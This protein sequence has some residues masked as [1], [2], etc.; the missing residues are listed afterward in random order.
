M[1][2]A[3]LAAAASAQELRPLAVRAGG[4]VD[5]R[6]G[7][8]RDA[9]VVEI[10]DGRVAAVRRGGEA[11]AAGP[12][13]CDLGSD[14]MLLP[15]LID[16]HAHL[17]MSPEPD[18]DYGE[19]SAASLALLGVVHARRTLLAGFT[20]VR[21]PFG[22][23]Y[24]DVALRDAI[25]AG[26]V[27]GPRM[28]VSG[29]GL[30]MTGGHGAVGNWAPPGLELR[31]GAASV[32]DGADAIRRE[33]RLH[34]KYGVD[35][36]KV[37]ATGGI[38]TEGTEPGAASYTREEIQAA[39]E[40]AVKRGQKVAAHAHGTQGIRNAVEAGVHSIEHGSFLDLATARLMVER[41]TFLVPDALADE[42]SLTDG[43]DATAAS[44]A[45]DKARAVSARFRESVR[46]AH[47]TGVRIAF[48]TD[49]GVYPHGLNGRQFALYVELGM[50]PMEAIVSATGDA[51]E[52]IGV[53]DRLGTI[54]P[55]ML[56]DLI[57]VRG[58]PLA[59]VG[60]LESIPFVMKGGRVVKND[61]GC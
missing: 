4:L 11:R 25:A 12:G 26:W 49:A 48:G 41:G 50:S 37:I 51:A 29:P 7:V 6:G 38:F 39:V 15:G 17:T 14:W 32:V 42:Y 10:R 40:E 2:L 59:D 13:V 56:A 23:H 24:A 44:G 22:P 28:Y 36:I 43:I 47:R 5:G 57:A 16:V 34:Q 33:V 21:D 9:V 58:D 1:A 60:V 20:T 30:T 27:E 54:E 52:L 8:V 46:L 45:L 18:L 19:L 35:F 61:G 53:R 3:L 31:S 55:G